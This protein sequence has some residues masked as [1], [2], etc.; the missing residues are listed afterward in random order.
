MTATPRRA[1]R[2]THERYRADVALYVSAGGEESVQRVINAVQSLDRKL[3]QW[4]ARQ[5]SDLDLSGGEW[6]VLSRLALADGEALT[7]TLLADAASVAPSSMT[8]RLDRMASRGLVHRRTDPQNRTRI[9]VTLTDAGWRAFKAAV[10]EA[11]LVES[12]VLRTL[13][14]QQRDQLAAL[15]EIVIG[16][17]DDAGAQ[18]A[19]SA[20][21]FDGSP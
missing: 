6:T 15:L 4:Y 2:S 10:R 17:I 7:P 20:E 1:A 19:E 11:N 8:H 13:S 16:G 5:L 9:L 18:D 3:R 14:P 12:D 21:G